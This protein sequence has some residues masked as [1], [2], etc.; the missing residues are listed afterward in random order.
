MPG[1]AVSR[2]Q[3]KIGLIQFNARWY[4]LWIGWTLEIML[5][6]GN[7]FICPGSRFLIVLPFFVWS[8]C[9]RLGTERRR[10][11]CYH[12]SRLYL[13]HTHTILEEAG[14]IFNY[15][16][17]WHLH[18]IAF[19]FWHPKNGMLCHMNWKLLRI[20]TLS[21]KDWNLIFFTRYITDLLRNWPEF[22]IF[23]SHLLLF[24]CF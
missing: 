4:G 1:M 17:T 12:V 19:L 5:A 22:L 20:C 14:T 16:A 11:T 9:S 8:I 21:K 7:C 24:Y 15:P 18:G 2:S 13:R 6:T 3:W 23:T 10:L